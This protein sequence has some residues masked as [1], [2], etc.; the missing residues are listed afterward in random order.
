M[1]D[2]QIR[3]EL[4]R[5]LD[6]RFSG[7]TETLIL[8]ELGLRHGAAR[9]DIAVI[10]G[11]L[12]GYEIKSD[13]DTLRRLPKQ[14]SIYNSV[15]DRVT[16]VVGS[17]HVDSAMLIIPEWWGVN[18]AE[19][20]QRGN[21][22][23]SDVRIP[24]SNPAPDPI[25]IAKLLWRDEALSILREEGAAAGFASK[26]RRIIYKRLAEALDLWSL[27]Q[28]VRQQLRDRKGWRSDGLQKLNDG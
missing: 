25:A 19:A 20:G 24:G 3:T 16:L 21:I 4:R 2:Y 13:L 28:R 11:S 7:D 9:I 8:D 1:N 17:R 26:P 14:M 22:H 6:Q 15:L 27:R 10:N 5:L 12:D 23:F 18:L